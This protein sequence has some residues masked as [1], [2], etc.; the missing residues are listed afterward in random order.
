MEIILVQGLGQSADVWQPVQKQLRVPSRT[1]DVFAG[2]TPNDSLTLS[3]LNDAPDNLRLAFAA[4][5]SC[6][7]NIYLA[8]DRKVMLGCRSV[9]VRTI[10]FDAFESVNVS[11][12]W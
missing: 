7:P 2:L 4:A 5:A 10:N 12:K 11:D 1:F 6:C 9:K 3:M 8:F